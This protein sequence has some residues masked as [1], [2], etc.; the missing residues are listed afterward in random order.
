MQRVRSRERFG[1]LA[2]AMVVATAVAAEEPTQWL[3]RMNQALTTRNYDGTFSHWH[4]GKVEM[5][6]II[7]RVQDGAVAERLV[8]LDGS[9]REFIRSG[10]DVACY[11]PDKKT[12]LVERRPADESLLGG[13]PAV[14]QQTASFYDIRE[15]ERTRLNRRDTHLITV[16]P[17]DEFRYGYRLWIDESTGMPLKT[18]LCDGRGRV[19]E[20]I[21]FAS[22]TL[23]SRIPDSAFKPE[24]STEG[25]Q[26]LRNESAPSK[27]P[28]EN[29][30][31][32]WNALKLPPGFKMAARSAQVL[33]GSTDPVSHLV[34]S[35]GLA[36][37]SVFVEMETKKTRESADEQT[38]TEESARLGSSSVYST[39][40]GGRKVTAVGEVPPATVRS[41]ASSFSSQGP[42]PVSSPHH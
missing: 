23:S 32:V 18:Q 13:F 2:L 27:E 42:T 17:K 21:V 20:Q 36:S 22:L 37:V 4:G 35:D 16:T 28:P 31:L 12:V 9:G 41:I 1:W 6:R 11:L 19:I 33:P 38:V 24:V 39:M 29:A 10:L 34:F 14:N 3:E 7:H 15:V 40:M 30:S 25:F 26:W 5:L 8:S